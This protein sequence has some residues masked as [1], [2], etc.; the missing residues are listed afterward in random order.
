M[1]P[2]DA[3]YIKLDNGQIGKF[4]PATQKKCFSLRFKKPRVYA[5]DF[6]TAIKRPDFRRQLTAGLKWLD[7][8]SYFQNGCL[9]VKWAY[10]CAQKR[11]KVVQPV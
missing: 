10:V 6:R 8:G 11:I 1:G 7:R 2:E 3:R 4:T 5:P 9:K